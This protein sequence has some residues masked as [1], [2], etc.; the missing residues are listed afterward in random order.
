ML[1]LDRTQRPLESSIFSLKKS[2][3]SN[4]NKL[5]WLI[6]KWKIKKSRSK[7]LSKNFDRKFTPGCITVVK[8]I[9]FFFFL[10]VIYP[11]HSIMFGLLGFDELIVI[12]PLR[13]ANKFH[14]LQPFKNGIKYYVVVSVI[15]D[16]WG[17][18][19]TV[20]S[21]LQVNLYY[22]FLFPQKKFQLSTVSL[23]KPYFL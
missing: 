5:F 10:F 14:V 16:L 23:P 20:R 22:F 11:K 18:S 6:I 17:Q 1:A 2:L 19:I 12:C 13:T 21:P 7:R 4:T 8:L 3:G 15:N 9:L